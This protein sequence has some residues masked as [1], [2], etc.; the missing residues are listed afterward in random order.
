MGPKH[1]YVQEYKLYHYN[2]HF[3]GHWS[4]KYQ[5]NSLNNSKSVIKFDGFYFPSLKIYHQAKLAKNYKSRHLWL[6]V[7]LLNCQFIAGWIKCILALKPQTLHALRHQP[8]S[9]CRCYLPKLRNCS[10]E[11]L[12]LKFHIGPRN[13]T[14]KPNIHFLNNILAADFISR[15]T[16]RL[17]DFINSKQIL[18]STYIR[19][20]R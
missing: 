20:L 17:K 10:A 6:I 9:D 1:F 14:S 5:Y 8:Q 12:S 16:S 4:K 18:E 7:Q 2:C 3:G 19:L 13:Y 11:R 15:H